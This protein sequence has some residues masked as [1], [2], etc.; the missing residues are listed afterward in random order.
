[1]S[2]ELNIFN[3]DVV[4][5][6]TRPLFFQYCGNVQEINIVFKPLGICHFLKESFSSIAPNFSQEYA[7]AQWKAFAP[8]LFEEESEELQISLLET[9]LLENLQAHD[10][11]LMYK[12]IAYLEDLDDELSIAEIASLLDMN[13]KTFQRHFYKH[14]A[15]TPSDYRR[16]VRFRRSLNSG[17]LSK[18]LKKLTALTYE[19]NYCDQSYFVREYKKLAMLSPRVFF[20]KISALNEHK[21]IWEIK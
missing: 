5:K 19:S 16:I 2:D 13:L 8:L 21:V 6:F 14:F 4:G 18:D 17:I 7:D 1:M 10:L 11:A 9:F 20:N 3:I 15:C 12:A